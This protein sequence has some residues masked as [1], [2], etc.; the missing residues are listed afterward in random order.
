MAKSII[1]FGA[2]IRAEKFLI[3]YYNKIEVDEIWDNVK[4]GKFHRYIIKKPYFKPN[5]FI[6]VTVDGFLPYSK[7]RQQLLELGYKEFEDFI[8]YTV[9]KKSIALAYGN[10]HMEA[11]KQYLELH[12]QFTEIYGFYPLPPIQS[13]QDTSQIEAAIP[14]CE[15]VIHQSIRKEN[16]YGEEYASEEILKHSS[17]N[18][19]IV[20]VPNLYGLPKCFFPQLQRR[21]KSS[22][23]LCDLLAYEEINIKKWVNDNVSKEE[24]QQVI[25]LGGVYTQE[26]IKGLWEEFQIKLEDREKEWDIKIS[27]YIYAHYRTEKLFTDRWHISTF[28]AKEI[29]NRV[30]ARLG[31]CSDIES[32]LPCLDDYEVFIYKD[33]KVA[34]GLEFEEKSIRNYTRRNSCIDTIEM[35]LMSYIEMCVQIYMYECGQ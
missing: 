15:L 1:L 23:L 28:L 5:V 25:S 29:A 13:M 21:E 32:V 20:S 7:I 9:Y 18:C 8:P 6:I 2:G 33:V 11:I 35:S 16:R 10:C 22:K 12:S 19:N 26:Y 24:I 17:K 34:L 4:I 27:D 14:K 31:Y 3:K 30:L